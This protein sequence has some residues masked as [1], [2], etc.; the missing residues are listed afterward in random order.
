MYVNT[1][2]VWENL[3]KSER[4]QKFDTYRFVGFTSLIANFEYFSAKDY[5]TL[6]HEIQEQSTLSLFGKIVI[7]PKT[8]KE[9]KDAL[10]NLKK[11]SDFLICVH[12]T[13]KDILTFAINDSRIDAIICPHIADLSHIT[14]GIISLLKT[15]G[16]FLEMS[17]RDVLGSKSH[18]RSRLFHEIHK[19][20]SI[21]SNNTQILLY[22]GCEK[23]IYE[24]RGPHE[25]A[26]IYTAI[27]DLTLQASKTIVQSNP[28][29]F[30]N[31]LLERQSSQHFS[32]GVKII[33]HQDKE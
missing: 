19:F 2:V 24:I 30:I 12:S 27:F 29:R 1:S 22:G 18:E 13:D 7:H 4:K 31:I 26:T 14:P 11:Y 9:L 16:K 25:I 8:L 32:Q 6:L 33:S 3:S 20:L 10:K 17:L 21:V 23:S 28:E 15:Q 5:R